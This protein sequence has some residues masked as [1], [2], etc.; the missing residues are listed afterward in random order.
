M[1]EA[2]SSSLQISSSIN[3]HPNLTSSVSSSPPKE[4]QCE[5]TENGKK[6]VVSE[7]VENSSEH[8]SDISSTFQLIHNQNMHLKSSRSVDELEI[9]EP[10]FYSEEIKGNEKT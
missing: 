4:L 6:S 8:I 2:H 5:C 1:N 3:I 10:V 9:E 7:N